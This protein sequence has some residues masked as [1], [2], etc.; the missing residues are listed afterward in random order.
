[1]PSQLFQDW[2]HKSSRDATLP[3]AEHYTDDEISIGTWVDPFQTGD[4]TILIELASPENVSI[5]HR[6]HIVQGD[7]GYLKWAN[8]RKGFLCHMHAMKAQISP[9]IHKVP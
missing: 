1:M 9:C 8:A 7:A 4:K 5:H 2:G 6:L 3:L